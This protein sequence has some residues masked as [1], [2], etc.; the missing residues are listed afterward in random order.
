MTVVASSFCSS[1]LIC[2]LYL[3]MS[4]G[5]TVLTCHSATPTAMATTATR[6]LT[7]PRRFFDFAAISCAETFFCL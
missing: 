6:P 4:T 2:S 5:S 7:R 3:A 1:P